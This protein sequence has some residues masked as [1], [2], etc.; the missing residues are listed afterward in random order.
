[1]ASKKRSKGKKA[2]KKR[3]KGSS[4]PTPFQKFLTRDPEGAY[5]KMGWT[6]PRQHRGVSG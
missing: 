6:L 4:G 3:A 1:M 2:S 5:R